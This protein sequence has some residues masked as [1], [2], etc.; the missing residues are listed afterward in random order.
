M[1]NKLGD[2]D[3][4]LVTWSSIS[5]KGNISDV[6]N[7]VDAGCRIIQYREKNK[8]TKQLITEAKKLKEICKN[9]AIFIVNDNIE[10]AL[11]VNADGVHL[12]QED[13]D[14]NTARKKL[15][16]NKIIGQTVHSLEEA[17][18]AEKE[19]ANYVGLAPIFETD[20]KKDTISPIGKETIKEIRDKINIPIVAVGG[21]TKENVKQ[22][23]STGADAAVSVSSVISSDDVFREVRRFIGLIR[24]AKTE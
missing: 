12:G 10:V 23:I 21:I 8:D 22:V 3:F 16:K 15:G 7:A 6:E 4:Y 17:E 2:I 11:E 13:I 18:N 9:K 1:L 19:G 24:E 5:K 20:T 14:I